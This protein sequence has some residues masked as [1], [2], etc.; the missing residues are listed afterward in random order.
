MRITCLQQATQIWL[1]SGS[2]MKDELSMLENNNLDSFQHLLRLTS[3][4]LFFWWICS[5]I[6]FF[7]KVISNL[8]VISI[9]DN[10]DPNDYNCNKIKYQYLYMW[11]HAC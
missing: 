1:K 8:Q 10:T 9:E 6:E 4:P 3:K 7:Y 5:I 2:E 11:T